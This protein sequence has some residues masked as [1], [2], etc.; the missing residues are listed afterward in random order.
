VAGTRTIL[1]PVR[2]SISRPYLEELDAEGTL[3]GPLPLDDAT[4]QAYASA[5][6]ANAAGSVYVLVNGCSSSFAG[7][8]V[9]GD[10]DAFVA[11]VR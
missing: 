4:D 6:A 3:L 5:V 2:S 7:Q 9:V 11:R 8:P 1:D 10:C